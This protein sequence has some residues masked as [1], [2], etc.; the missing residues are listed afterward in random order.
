MI[1]GLA[2]ESD[3]PPRR[4]SGSLAL[5]L[6][7]DLRP[8]KAAGLRGISTMRAFDLTVGKPLDLAD[9]LARAVRESDRC[10]GKP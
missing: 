10:H 3:G 2:S 9:T 6:L 8:H 4:G 5:P 7:L 1:A